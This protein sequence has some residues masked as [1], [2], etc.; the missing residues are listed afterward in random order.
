MG[1][2]ELT[3]NISKNLNDH[4]KSVPL[5]YLTMTQTLSRF[6][7]FCILLLTFL[8]ILLFIYFNNNEYKYAQF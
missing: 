4:N 2:I 6:N 5:F 1:K 7:L 3:E 8:F